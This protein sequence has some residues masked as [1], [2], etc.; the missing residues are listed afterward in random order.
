MAGADDLDGVDRRTPP[1]PRGE[2]GVVPAGAH[3]RRCGLGRLLGDIR[4]AVTGGTPFGGAFLGEE[5][6]VLLRDSLGRGV[7]L[8]RPA[9]IGQAY[10]GSRLGDA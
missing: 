8:G 1:L 2:G 5:A 3:R 9:Y 6:R 10:L 7:G 4:E